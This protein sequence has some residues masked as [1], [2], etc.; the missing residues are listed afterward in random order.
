MQLRAVLS[1][2]AASISF[3]ACPMRE[4]NGFGF[5]RSVG[6]S[7]VFRGVRTSW[8][9]SRASTRRALMERV[10]AASTAALFGRDWKI[11]GT[12]LVKICGQEDMFELKECSIV[13]TP[14][15]CCQVLILR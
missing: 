5:V 12:Y 6:P 1:L 13:G 4:W 7:E 9:R 3:H 10:M 8:T 11:F 15:V 2:P 14:V